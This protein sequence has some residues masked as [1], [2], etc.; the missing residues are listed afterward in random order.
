MLSSVVL[1]ITSIPD[2]P[3]QGLPVTIITGFLGSGKTTLLQRLLA[4]SAGQKIAA[5]VNDFGSLNI[6]Q[7]LLVSVSEDV[8]ELS[9]GCLC[10]TANESLVDTVYEILER[11]ERVDY[12]VIETTGVAD[13]IPLL[14][15]FLGSE[16]KHLTRLDAVLT[17]IDSSSFDTEHYYS[18]AALHQLQYSDQILLTKTDL[19]DV[20]QQNAVKAAIY[21]I[22]E[23]ARIQ[24]CSFGDIPL[25]L[26]L[27]LGLSPQRE[28]Q[29]LETLNQLVRQQIE[30]DG[31]TAFPF[32]SHQ[33][34]DLNRFE[35]FLN[36]ELPKGICRAKGLLSFQNQPG[37]YVFQLSGQRFSVDRSPSHHVQGNQ[38][39]LIGRH[40]NVLDLIQRLNN[41]LA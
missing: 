18:Q 12:L 23:Q 37:T 25:S 26:I 13:P 40:F 29:E 7:Q 19:I 16:L 8:L 33:P 1:D 31:F 28:V 24:T 30:G 41:C 14:L 6:D 5:I 22:K 34:F 9:N 11:P 17:L 32:Q 4:N 21:S 2:L 27:D 38:L 10:C 36:F 35:N 15:T 3:K 39:V 20:H